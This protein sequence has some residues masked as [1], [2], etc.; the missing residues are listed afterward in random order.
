[1]L[2]DVMSACLWSLAGSMVACLA[3]HSAF[4]FKK[5]GKIDVAAVLIGGAE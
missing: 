3:I 4:Y 2:H 5:I 1:M